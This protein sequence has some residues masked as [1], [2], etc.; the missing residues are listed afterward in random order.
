MKTAPTALPQHQG[1]PVPWITRWSGEVNGDPL[2]VGFTAEGQLHLYYADGREDRDRHGVLWKR[3]GLGRT[4]EPQ[5]AEVNTYRQRASMTRR[6]CQMCGSKIEDRPMRWLMDRSQLV[7]EA[8]LTLTVSPPTCAACVPLALELC[9]HLRTHD[10]VVLK[11]L[12]Y[13]VW[14]VYAQPAAV[15]RESGQGRRLPKRFFPYDGKRRT[16]LLSYQQVAELTKFVIEE[17]L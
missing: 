2:S 1:R 16:G 7:Q 17:E 10:A 5:F 8:G 13:Q 12:E 3:E 4:G 9:P 11:V 15:D 6:L 14:G